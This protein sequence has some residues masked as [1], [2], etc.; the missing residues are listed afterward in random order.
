MITFENIYKSFG[1]NH[2]LRGVNLT[3]E[4]GESMVDHWRVGHRKICFDQNSSGSG[5]TGQRADFGGRRGC[6]A[7]QA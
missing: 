5:G 6:H 2:V 3:V 7:S 1:E 4:R